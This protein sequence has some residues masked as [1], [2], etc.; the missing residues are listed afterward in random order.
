MTYEEYWMGRAD[1]HKSDLTPEIVANAAIL[2]ERVHKLLK[3]FGEDR[4]VTSGWRPPSVNAA[5]VGAAVKSKH[6]S[7]QAIDLA[8]PEDDLD[9]WCLANQDKLEE[10]QLWLESPDATPKWCHLQMVPPKSGRRVFLP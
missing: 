8:D 2:V 9:A 4:A 6:M 10:F 5:T 1:T 7:G 3:A